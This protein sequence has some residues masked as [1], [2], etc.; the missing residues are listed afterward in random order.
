MYGVTV[1]C[2]QLRP[3]VCGWSRK[4]FQLQCWGAP[5]SR[6]LDVLCSLDSS[7]DADGCILQ[8]PSPPQAGGLHDVSTQAGRQRIVGFPL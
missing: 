5:E 4:T 2:V 3:M 6:S 8:Q 1:R 7:C